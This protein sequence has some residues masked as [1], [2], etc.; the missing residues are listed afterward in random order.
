MWKCITGNAF[1]NTVK[2]S[3]P[4]IQLGPVYVKKVIWKLTNFANQYNGNTDNDWPAQ[5]MY[6]SMMD[7]VLKA[8]SVLKKYIKQLC[9]FKKSTTDL[10]K[11]KFLK[12]NLAL[13][14]M[15]MNNS[16]KNE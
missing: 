1:S 4:N 13:L 10:K 15:K 11:K 16:W 12:V 14:G 2:F 9:N 8:A 5:I 6:F 7:D 3:R